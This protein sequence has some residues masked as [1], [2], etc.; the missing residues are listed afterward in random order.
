MSPSSAPST[1]SSPKWFGG[2]EIVGQLGAGGM[3]TVYLGRDP[4]RSRLVAVKLLAEPATGNR[5]AR[6][7]FAVE[8][9][10]LA[11]IHHANVVAELG[12][13]EAG[14]Q[15]YLIHELVAGPRLDE[16]ERPAPW[17]CVLRVG[18]GLARAVAAVHAAGVLHR[19]IKPSNVMLSDGGAVKLI[20]FGLAKLHDAGPRRRPRATTAAAVAAVQVGP[21]SSD[22]TL[23]GAGSVVGTPRYL[24]PEMWAGAPASVRTDLYAMGLVL[25]L[26]LD[27]E[28]PHGGLRGKDLASAVRFRD[29][30]RLTGRLPEVPRE[31]CEVIDACVERD[32]DR[33]PASADEVVDALETLAAARATAVADA[34]PMVRRPA[35]TVRGAAADVAVTDATR[36]LPFRSGRAR[37]TTA[38]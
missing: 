26:L 16:L 36:P 12:S 10:A 3:G 13:G 24:A 34:R 23:T 21:G 29:L 15:P 32:P 4:V 1:W 2:V 38:A 6:E 17:P 30:P 27:G 25:Y 35:P 33:R 7:R 9:T 22:R 8:A 37:A 19:D 31:L 28:L 14:G 11:R 5:H 20:D 18:V